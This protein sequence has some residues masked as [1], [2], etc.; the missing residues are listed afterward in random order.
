[1]IKVEGLRV[2][3]GDFELSEVNFEVGRGEYFV[4]LGPTGAGKTV[5]LE[6]IAG[7]LPLKEG[8]IFINGREATRLPPERRKVGF[9]FQDYMLFPHLSVRDNIAF[10]LKGRRR[11]EA[12]RRVEELAEL[13]EI[14]HLLSRKP[15]TLSGGEKQKVALARALAP[16]PEILLLDEPLSA[17]DPKTREGLARELLRIHKKL[18]LTT[19]H[20][21]HDFEEALALGERVAVMREG[22]IVQIGTPEEIFRRPASEFVAEFA[23]ARNLFRGEV[24]EEEGEVFFVT[25]EGAKFIVSTPIR[26]EAWASLRPEDILLSKTPLSSSARNCLKGRI[27]QV[28]EQERGFLVTVRIPPDITCF[29]TRSSFEELEV[30]EGDEAFITFKASAIHIF[31]I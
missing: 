21:T 8:R 25:R 13:L 20:V 22:R 15:Q 2:R 28:R 24:R 23:L 18:G 11:E 29:I 17:L 14:K 12:R 7:L 16:K 1:M 31:G 9:V 3:L 6:A 26:G 27:V 5:L 10:G 4:I 19:L 30:R